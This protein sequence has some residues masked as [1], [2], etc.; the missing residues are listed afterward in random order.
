[1]LIFDV[2]TPYH[3]NYG[4]AWEVFQQMQFSLGKSRFNYSLRSE[5]GSR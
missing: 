1:M 2:R 5:M 3:T 4:L